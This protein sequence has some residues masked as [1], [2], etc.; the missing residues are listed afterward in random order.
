MEPVKDSKQELTPYQEIP[1]ADAYKVHKRRY[2]D[3][4]GP[5]Q[6][7]SA[8]T[9]SDSS[10]DDDDVPN[11]PPDLPNL[12]GTKLRFWWFVS[13]DTQRLCKLH[14]SYC[15]NAVAV[16]LYQPTQPNNVAVLEQLAVGNNRWSFE[17]VSVYSA[18]TF[19]NFTARH[20]DLA[21]VISKNLV[22]EVH[23]EKKKA[24]KIVT[25]NQ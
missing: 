15:P 12:G 14:D 21:K 8:E 7:Q 1:D 9:E 20:P 18:I 16:R 6:A 19:A 3:P 23:V 10:S 2:N 24:P 17:R 13:T 11:S 22:L 25:V 5:A 4:D